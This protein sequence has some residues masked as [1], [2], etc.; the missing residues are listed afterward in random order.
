MQ[1]SASMDKLQSGAN[2]C[3]EKPME[4]RLPTH[5]TTFQGW[6]GTVPTVVVKA[7]AL[8]RKCTQMLAA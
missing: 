4:F 6:A 1:L 8:T 7:S 2:C 3:P 5:S